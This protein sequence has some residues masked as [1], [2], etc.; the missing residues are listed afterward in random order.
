MDLTKMTAQLREGANNIERCIEKIEEGKRAAAVL[1][2]LINKQARLAL[3]I[4]YWS[5]QETDCEMPIDEFI[6]KLT[7]TLKGGV[8]N[9]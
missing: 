9:D 6:E 8:K 3:S 2:N 7:E 1:P 4:K 5:E